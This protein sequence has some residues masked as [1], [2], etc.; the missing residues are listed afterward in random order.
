ME[1]MYKERFEQKKDELHDLYMQLYGNDA[2]FAELCE[3][4]YAFYKERSE[5]LKTLDKKREAD[6][7]WYRKN[8]MLGMMFY[9]DNF[10]GNMKGVESKLDYL[11]K[12]NVNYIHLMPFLDT[13]EGRSDGGYAVSDFRKVQE[14]LG[15]MEDLEHLT[16]EM[17]DLQSENEALKSR[18]AK[19]ALG[20]VMNQIE[21]VKGVKLLA[22]SV[23][24]VDMNGLRDLGDQLKDKIGEGVVVIASDCD[25]K[26]NLI[27]MAT[28]AAM[29][30]GAHAG[31]LIKAI[32]GN[33]G[34]GGGGRP[35]MAQAGGKNPA[36]IPDAIAQA[37]TALEN[38]LK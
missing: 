32:A 4:L 1:T 37:K 13:P 7:N 30:Q 2:M 11:E 6:P 20:D 10:A 3:H 12:N 18:A 16:A 5:K 14:K 8:D 36:G 21:D 15:T 38:M 23:S 33:V 27:A 31:N 17:K 29:K 35:N 19:D 26:V 22:T 28:D 25:G 34:G 24:G 9:I